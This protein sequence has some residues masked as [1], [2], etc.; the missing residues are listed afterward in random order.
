MIRTLLFTC[1]LSLSAWQVTAQTPVKVYSGESVPTEQGWTEQKLDA[2]VNS[3]A[4]PT[5]QAVTDGVLKLTSTNE[6]NQFSQLLW[7]KPDLDLGFETGFI[8]EI[9]AK[10]KSADKTGAFNIQGFDKAGRG[11]RI[12]I[13]NNAVTE[14]TNPFAATN[15]LAGD[16]NNGNDFHIYRIVAAP[17][18]DDNA[19]VYR[20][21]VLL[22]TFQ[23][24]FFQFDNI[25]ENGGFED[26]EFPDFISAATLV[27]VDDP[28]KKSSGKYSL[29]MSNNGMVT[30]NW[31]NPELARTREIAVKPG[32]KYELY[33]TRRRTMGEPYCWRDF[34]AF[35]DFQS[36]TLGLKGE[37][38]D[39]RVYN[40]TWGSCN[41]DTWQ[42]HSQD[43]AAPTGAKTIRLEF[44][45]WIRDDSK[46]DVSTSLDNVTLRE[47]PALLVGM[48]DHFQPPLIPEGVINLIKN[49]SFEDSSINNDGT[50]YNWALSD[51]ERVNDNSPT[52]YNPLWGGL[53][54]L[55]TFKKDD[56]EVQGDYRCSGNNALRWTT[57]ENY[58]N[59]LDFKVILEPNKTYRFNFWYAL[60][61]WGEQGWLKLKINNTTENTDNGTVIWGQKLLPGWQH[62][63]GWQNSDVVFTTTETDY[64]LHLYDGSRNSSWWNLHF[65]DFMLYEVTPEQPIDPQVAGKANLLANADFEDITK[66]NDGSSYNWALSNPENDDDAFPMAYNEMWGT[67]LRIQDK[68]QREVADGEWNNWNGNERF[69]TGKQWAHSGTKSVRFTFMD[70]ID[71]ARAFEGLSENET[72]QA[73]RLNMNFQK[74]LAP[75]RTYTF[76]FWIKTSCWN[77]RGWF[78]IANGDMIV[79]SQELSNRY[80]N[81][82]RQSVT[83]STTEENHTLRMYTQFGG[84]M[85]FYLDDLFLFEED[86]HTPIGGGYLAFGKSTGT[87]ST[88]V[89]I[90][91]ITI[92]KGNEL[93]VKPV[94]KASNLKIYPNPVVNGLLTVADIQS[95]DGYIEI[96]SVLGTLVSTHNIT[97][98][99]TTINVSALPA[100]TYI[101]KVDGKKAILLKK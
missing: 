41:D 81:W 54:R 94:L 25:I 1:I 88:D 74:E 7:Y 101:V 33:I 98:A 72:P 65:D 2:T 84:W 58:D 70:N 29:E 100:G 38:R 10:I 21:D 76:V 85:N 78:H 9:I 48:T 12:G 4:A 45:T 30:N 75:N 93:G 39:N 69:D 59:R 24:Q 11:F 53:V 79:L 77:D 32:A 28:E 6:P 71:A 99:T 90:K 52:E 67:W 26:A 43:F 87:S 50:G 86:E 31:L 34:G 95:V 35:Y 73:Y 3:L 37:N 97:G 83:F 89:E 66:N 22:G 60:P 8:I 19:K 20:D 68:E 92:L 96:Y 91:S 49:G 5:T 61:K 13:L 57:L 17:A 51:P 64:I 80:M 27:R 62:W 40:V 14:Q 18:P 16:L 36:G 63:I 15:I 23:L 47:K 55:Q 42:T 82:S 56:D 46:Y 44:P